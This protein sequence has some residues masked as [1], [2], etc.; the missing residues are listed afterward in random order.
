MVVSAVNEE[1][2][3]TGTVTKPR[4]RGKKLLATLVP[5]GVAFDQQAPRFVLGPLCNH[6][7]GSNADGG[8]L[9]SFGCGLLKTDWK[10]TAN[11]TTPISAAHPFEL[12]LDGLARVTG[13]AP[14]YF[15]D[16]FANA[17]LE[18][19]TGANIQRRRVITSTTVTAGA[20][21]V[22]LDRWFT[23]AGPADNDAVVLYPQCDG[24]RETCKA[25]H[26]STNPA[27]KFNNDDNFG[28]HPFI[29]QGNPSAYDQ[30]SLSG[31][32]G[33]K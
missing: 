13:S 30:T 18:W 9:M 3:F 33:K 1:V 23:G 20:L 28:G 15:A 19:G 6:V 10:F 7:I 26:V 27:G 12:N 25:Y 4:V 29:P 32:G 22:T 17:I 11:V 14:T 16:W 8:F 24:R 31:A 2:I 5:G 21:T